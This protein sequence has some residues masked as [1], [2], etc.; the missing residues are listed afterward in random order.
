[1]HPYGYLRLRVLGEATLFGVIVAPVGQ[2]PV[3][4]IVLAAPIPL[5]DADDDQ[6]QYQE[7]NGQHH[8]DEP[9]GRGH[10]VARDDD[11]AF[12]GSKNRLV[13][14][15]GVLTIRLLTNS[16]GI[17]ILRHRLRLVLAVHGN[18]LEFVSAVRFQPV[19]GVVVLV[20]DRV[21]HQPLVVALDAVLYEEVRSRFALQVR[22]PRDLDVRLAITVRLPFPGEVRLIRYN[23]STASSLLFDVIAAGREMQF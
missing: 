6:Q 4:H 20:Q 7:R 1:M 21:R 13:F 11:G 2:F 12:Y 16:R 10:V 18:N 8:S 9:P 19:H 17:N 23:R 5:D 22:L 15:T 14:I 3:V